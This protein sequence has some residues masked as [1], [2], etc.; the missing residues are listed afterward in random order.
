MEQ[1]QEVKKFQLKI[2]IGKC[3]IYNKIHILIQEQCEYWARE[4]LTNTS[5]YGPVVEDIESR[6]REVRGVLLNQELLEKVL[7]DFQDE[8]IILGMEARIWWVDSTTLYDI[9]NSNEFDPDFPRNSL[10]LIETVKVLDKPIVRTGDLIRWKCK[11][12]A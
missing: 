6:H 3:L 10:P 12:I 5:D 2:W 7:K 8:I 9:L 11:R 4:F 1:K